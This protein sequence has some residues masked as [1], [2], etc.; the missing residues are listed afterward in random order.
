MEFDIDTTELDAWVAR[1]EAAIAA[2]PE[3]C[4]RVANEGGDLLSLALGLNAPFDG[5][6]NNGVLP[7]EVGHLNESFGYNEA[8]PG[9]ECTAQVWTSQPIKYGYVTQGTA[10]PIFPVQK[11]AMW[12]PDAAHPVGMVR[13][14]EANPF[15]E[16]AKSDF[17]SE[18]PGY[19]NAIVAEWLGEI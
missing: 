18:F 19:A 12:W 2:A 16:K 10:T 8:T 3:M 5:A 11:L 7:N 9:E 14:Q 1:I 6:A 15:Q 17:E 13:G 4:A